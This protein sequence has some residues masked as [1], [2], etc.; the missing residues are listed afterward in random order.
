MKNFSEIY[1]KVKPSI[2]A[3]ASKISTNPDFPD[4]IGTGFVVKSDGV[5]LT[6]DHIIKCLNKLPR[7]KD[8]KKTEW[9]AFVIYFHW[10]ADKGMALIPLEIQGVGILGRTQ[11]VEGYNYGPKIPDLGFIRVNIK[12]LPCVKIAEK[13]NLNEGD[14]IIVS[15]F[16]MGTA[17]LRAPGWLHQLS[18]TLQAGLISAILPFPCENPHAILL[19]IMTQGGSSGSPV[20]N[21]IN[22]EVIGIVYAGLIDVKSIK[23]GSGLLIY[24]TDTSLTL[25]IP[26]NIVSAIYRKIDEVPEYREANT[27]EY[28]TI[29]SFISKRGYEISPPKMP[30]LKPI[31]SED[32]E[33]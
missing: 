29:E 13:F 6:N 28:E 16:P 12:D 10:I 27:S 25:A 5:I 14:E 9:P 33:I 19:D 32:V 26:A 30:T 1:K 4:I 11:Q 20:F 8:M 3:I 23:G 2:I 31:K 17:T 24:Q 21:S 15:G 22:G 18:P 7:Q